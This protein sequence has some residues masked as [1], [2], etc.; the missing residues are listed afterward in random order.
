MQQELNRAFNS[1]Q[2]FEKNIE[3]DKQNQ[4]FL[5]RN[6]QLGRVEPKELNMFSYRMQRGIDFLNFPNEHGGFL[7]RK[8]GEE[9]IKKNEALLVLSGS[10]RGFVREINQSSL[11]NSKIQQE[12]RG[13]LS[14]LFQK[15]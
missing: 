15:K 11:N 6:F 13:M 5:N 9:L 4:S 1:V 3:P 7:T 2:L 14:D 10:I 12:T 8:Y